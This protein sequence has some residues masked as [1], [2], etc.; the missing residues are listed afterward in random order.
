METPKRV[1]D[2]LWG[3]SW[4]SCE[5]QIFRLSKVYK[6][7]HRVT[8]RRTPHT[9]FIFLFLF[10]LDLMNLAGHRHE[11]PADMSARATRRR[12]SEKYIQGSQSNICIMISHCPKDRSSSS[13]FFH[14]TPPIHEINITILKSQSDS[15][16]RRRY[17][18]RATQAMVRDIHRLWY[19]VGSLLLNFQQNFEEQRLI[20]SLISNYTN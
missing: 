12:C 11:A 6:R 14:S 13:R 1:D 9:P 10:H 8:W 16:R 3:R 15:R 20:S 17:S 19:Q 5:N 18:P 2:S 7:R 4:S